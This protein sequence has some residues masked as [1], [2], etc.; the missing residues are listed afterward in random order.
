MAALEN[1][2]AGYCTSSG[3]GARF[4]VIPNCVPATTWW[5]AT[6]F[7]AVHMFKEYLPLKAHIQSYLV[8]IC[9]LGR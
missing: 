8:D 5:S 3:M 1:A 6:P 7:T 9:N 4:R 2:E